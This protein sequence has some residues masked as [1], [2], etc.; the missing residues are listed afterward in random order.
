[1][2]Q[3]LLIT[4]FLNPVATGLSSISL[5]GAYGTMKMTASYALRKFYETI[6]RVEG[7]KVRYCAFSPTSSS[8]NNFE[9][10][11]HFI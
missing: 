2:L 7:S 3:T 5:K 6:M 4:Y 10:R 9:I 1:M 11:T 8:I